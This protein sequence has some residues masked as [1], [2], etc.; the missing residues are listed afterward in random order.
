MNAIGNTLDRINEFEFMRI[1]IGAG[2]YYK[3]VEQLANFTISLIE[4]FVPVPPIAS[5]LAAAWILRH[6]VVENFLGRY[7]SYYASMAAAGQALDSQFGISH[8]VSELLAKLGV[9]KQQAV[10]GLG[11]GS[12]PAIGGAGNLGAVESSG[13]LGQLPGNTAPGIDADMYEE[14]MKQ[15]KIEGLK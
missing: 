14:W 15:A 2:A 1:P 10:S 12:S 6:P 9:E 8:L 11:V 13:D 7:G 5:G 4:K 3:A